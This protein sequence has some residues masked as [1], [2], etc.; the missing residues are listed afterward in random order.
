MLRA[1]QAMQMSRTR[2][3]RSCLCAALHLQMTVARSS[4]SRIKRL[5]V[6]HVVKLP[7]HMYH[8]FNV[9][10]SY[11]NTQTHDSRL[12]EQ[13]CSRLTS[14]CTLIQSTKTVN[15]EICHPPITAVVGSCVGATDLRPTPFYVIST[16]M[17]RHCRHRK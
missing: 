10:R 15:T 7:P 6:T 5:D 3:S 14:C 2:S 4:C 13:L 16:V 1:N 12:S 11:G 17:P 9:N 8:N